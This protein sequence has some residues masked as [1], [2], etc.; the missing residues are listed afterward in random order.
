M[1]SRSIYPDGKGEVK[2]LNDYKNWHLISYLIVK[3]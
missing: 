3:D 1:L 2:K